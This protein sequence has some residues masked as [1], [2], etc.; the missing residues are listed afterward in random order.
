MALVTALL[1]GITWFDKGTLPSE[2]AVFSDAQNIIGS[3][4]AGLSFVGACALLMHTAAPPGNV[5]LADA[6]PVQNALR[7]HHGVQA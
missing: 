3:F 2:D 1:F 4:Y 6:V 7:C 5:E